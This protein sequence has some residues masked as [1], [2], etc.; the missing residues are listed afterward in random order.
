MA[1]I[2]ETQEL[3]VGLNE[4]ALCLIKVLKDGVQLSDV[5]AIL[6][7]LNDDAEFKAKIEAAYQGMGALAGELSDLQVGEILQLARTQIDY[8]DDYIDAIK[9]V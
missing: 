2:K 5:G 4:V 3:M 7:K 9:A 1:G 6:D 8:I